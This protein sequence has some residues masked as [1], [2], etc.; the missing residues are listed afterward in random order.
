V[1]ATVAIIVALGSLLGGGGV[2]ALVRIAVASSDRRADDWREIARTAQAA[3]A[4]SSEHVAQLIPAVQQLAAA[5]RE[6]LALLQ[7][8]ATERRGAA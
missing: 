3:A 1:S 7:G 4:V 6:S 2:V 5:Q 8:M